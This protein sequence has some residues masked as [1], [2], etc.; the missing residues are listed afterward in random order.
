MNVCLCASMYVCMC[1]CVCVCAD[2]VRVSGGGVCDG[3]PVPWEVYTRAAQY[4]GDEGLARP[5]S[6]VPSSMR[7]TGAPGA[8]PADMPAPAETLEL[9]QMYTGTHSTVRTHE[10]T[11][12]HTH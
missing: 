3:P 6:A 11:H 5:S 4:A 9:A 2:G 10:H 8:G 7:P 1:V 12:T